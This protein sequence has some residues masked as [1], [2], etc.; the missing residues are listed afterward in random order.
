MTEL[1]WEYVDSELM[2]VSTINNKQFGAIKRNTSYID[3]K[4]FKKGRIYI[5]RTTDKPSDGH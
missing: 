4:A 5:Q 2:Q 1:C 3:D